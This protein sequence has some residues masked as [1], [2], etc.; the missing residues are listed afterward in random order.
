MSARSPVLAALVLAGLCGCAGEAESDA[1]LA[2]RLLGT[3]Q[4]PESRTSATI[5]GEAT[6][7]GD[8]SVAGFVVS[9]QRTAGGAEVTFKL[10]AHWKVEGGVVHMRDF[11]TEPKGLFP[12][13]HTQRYKIV[14]LTPTEVVFR[15]LNNGAE[16]YRRRRQSF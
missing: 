10:R 8:G 3:W 2:A 16:L 5:K 14:A 9:P 15:D 12:A 4:A 7:S 11:E 13:G 1:S 6:Y